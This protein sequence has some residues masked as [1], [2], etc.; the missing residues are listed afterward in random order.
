MK[1]GPGPEGL[2]VWTLSSR[3]PYFSTAGNYLRGNGGVWGAARR[4]SAVTDPTKYNDT[5]FTYANIRCEKN[6]LM[7]TR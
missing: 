2:W 5:C 3:A 4:G 1:L 7:V 6:L